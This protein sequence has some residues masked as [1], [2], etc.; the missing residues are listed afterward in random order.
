M[1]LWDERNHETSP[2]NTKD[3][4]R[5]KLFLK[6]LLCICVFVFQQKKSQ[7]KAVIFSARIR[8]HKYTK[9]GCKVYFCLRL[10][11]CVFVS[12]KIVFV[13]LLRPLEKL[14]FRSAVIVFYSGLY[15]FLSHICFGHFDD[16]LYQLARARRLT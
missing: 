8:I 12:G 11:V 14:T 9:D 1:Y 16:F 2:E 5:K 4:I 6:V 7:P 10:F 13:G 15:L 3:T